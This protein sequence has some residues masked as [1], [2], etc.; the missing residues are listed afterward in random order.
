M[1][2]RFTLPKDAALVLKR[3]RDVIPEA[4][5]AA[6]ATAWYQLR[7]TAAEMG[8]RFAPVQENDAEAVKLAD[9][10]HLNG[11]SS[12]FI[13]W[14]LPGYVATNVQ[15]LRALFPDDARSWP[16][17]NVLEKCVRNAITNRVKNVGQNYGIANLTQSST[18]VQNQVR[19]RMRLAEKHAVTQSA[20]EAGPVDEVNT[21]EQVMADVLLTMPNEIERIQ[22]RRA[23]SYRAH[24]MN[25][26]VTAVPLREHMQML[27]EW[28]KRFVAGYAKL[29]ADANA[30]T[31]YNSCLVAGTPALFAELHQA[32]E[33]L[34][35]LGMFA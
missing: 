17:G 14:W 31:E 15:V 6:M 3:L 30:L 16:A 27:Q 11:K 23:A 25:D 32:D 18:I 22:E 10:L 20:E 19:K 26:P 35:A 7:L 1:G 28:S 5:F 33:E 29:A 12:E 34:R 4:E 2:K 8:A 13:E 24:G 9:V 21:Y